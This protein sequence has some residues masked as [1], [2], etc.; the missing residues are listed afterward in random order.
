MLANLNFLDI[1]Q[2]PNG[3]FI[4][5]YDCQYVVGAYST[6]VAHLQKTHSLLPRR[7][8]TLLDARL[9]LTKLLPTTLGRLPLPWPNGVAPVQGL[10]VF[11]GYSCL[12]CS[13]CTVNK[14]AM[15]RHQRKKH[16]DYSKASYD[17]V[18]L[19]T[20]FA[21]RCGG[22]GV[23]FWKVDALGPAPPA[24]PGLLDDHCDLGIRERA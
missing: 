14:D 9:D 5:C 20:W 8:T 12:H 15:G 3:P 18:Q 2:C 13:L 17:T 19:Q 4:I 24:W 21:T 6:L 1:V 10:P 11:R 7:A 23:W 16:Q 22:P